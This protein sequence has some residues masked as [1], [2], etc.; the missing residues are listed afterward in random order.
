MLNIIVFLITFVLSMT[1]KPMDVGKQQSIKKPNVLFIS[2]DDLRYQNGYFENNVL[3]TPNISN[4]VSEGVLFSNHFVQVPTCGASCY[5]LL[6]G[7]RPK[8]RKFRSNN[9]FVKEISNKE[10]R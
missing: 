7:Q 1:T 4:L 3:Q 10:E 2:I 9:I 6:T 5:S 8:T